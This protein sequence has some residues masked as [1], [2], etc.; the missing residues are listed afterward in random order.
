MWFFGLHSLHQ[1]P[2]KPLD[3]SGGTA[4]FYRLNLIQ[5]S[6]TDVSSEE[7]NDHLFN[8]GPFIDS[9]F[10]PQ[11]TSIGR[12]D[13]PHL[14]LT[15]KYIGKDLIGAQG[16]VEFY[17]SLC[18]KNSSKEQQPNPS[19]DALGS[20]CDFMLPYLGVLE[21]KKTM[22]SKDNNHE[23]PVK[24]L[25]LGNFADQKKKLRLLDLKIGKQ[26]V[27]FGWKGKSYFSAM[28]QTLFDKLTNSVNEGFRLE[29]FDG[30]PPAFESMKFNKREGKW[31]KKLRRFRYQQLQGI[32]IFQNLLDLHLLD[33]E[34]KYSD[35]DLFYDPD[36]YLEIIMNEIVER[37]TKLVI[38]CHEVKIPQKWI[39]SSLAIGYD[40]GEIPR[41]LRSEEDIRDS[42][43]ISIFDWGKSEL[44]NSI[45]MKDLK[46]AEVKSTTR[47]WNEYKN[48]I[49]TISWIATHKY[50]TRFCCPNWNYLTFMIYDYD[51]TAQD[52]FICEATVRME[53]TE[54]REVPLTRRKKGDGGSLA[55]SIVWKEF[56]DDS[57]LKGAWKIKIG[58]GRNLP[59]MDFHKPTSDPY[60]VLRPRISIKSHE[61]FQF[62]Q[63]T[64]MIQNNCDP[65][66]NETFSIPV[67]RNNDFRFLS[68]ALANAGLIQGEGIISQSKQEWVDRVAASV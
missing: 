22:G 7:S 25:V 9:C 58:K 61:K 68:S 47:F 57:R 31:S 15:T 56:P 36:E 52:D 18:G 37:L 53:V 20:L 60:V 1:S 41:R 11:A 44:N 5:Q 43:I 4:A 30:R 8:T 27:R 16:D 13:E 38:A 10:S 12:S 48:G 55:Y 14:Y 62:E 50:M 19:R 39:G 35:I 28:K 49:E 65:E 26:T 51:A 59:N 63:I 21:T 34:Q 24:L 40:V 42:T 33:D 66:W 54:M 29:G 3:V 46:N 6:P 67:C 32:K 2:V 17:E 45:K 64:K 23:N